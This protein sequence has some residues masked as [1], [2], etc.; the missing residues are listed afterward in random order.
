M[1]NL[2]VYVK[3]RH[4]HFHL[5]HSIGWLVI[6]MKLEA[7]YRHSAACCVIL[8]FSEVACF[9]NIFFCSIFEDPVVNGTAVA[10]T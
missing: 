5:T 4:E 9:L 2:Q 6:V 1:R 3:Y 7:K 10:T 8:Y